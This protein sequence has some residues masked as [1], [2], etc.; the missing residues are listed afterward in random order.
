MTDVPLPLTDPDAA[1]E[2][3]VETKGSARKEI[4]GG[5]GEPQSPYGV[6]G[7]VRPAG[8]S[9]VGDGVSRVG[10]KIR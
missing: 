8:R 10:E 3:E 2:T 4:L 1:V 5:P 7:R 6:R 9:I